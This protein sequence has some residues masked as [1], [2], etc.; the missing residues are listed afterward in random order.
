[1]RDRARKAGVLATGL[2]LA[3]AEAFAAPFQ[4]P[5]AK[6]P[7]VVDEEGLGIHFPRTAADHLAVAEEYVA[8][9]A[10][11]REDAKLHRRMLAAYERLVADLA[12]SPAPARKGGITVPLGSV[13]KTPAQH[14]FEYRAHCEAYIHGAEA[15]A[16]EANAM[17]KFHRARARELRD[18][19]EP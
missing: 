18:A 10:G 1:M 14:L 2:L 12:A 4:E 7:L 5:A 11:W 9:A 16:D 13:Q 8:K 3:V 15:L 17:A 19:K 6:P